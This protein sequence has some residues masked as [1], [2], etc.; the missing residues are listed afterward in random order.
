MLLCTTSYNVL[1]I[2]CTASKICSVKNQNWR[3]KLL[4][5]LSMFKYL[6]C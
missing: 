4:Q 3:K 5:F 1:I 6:M 2:K